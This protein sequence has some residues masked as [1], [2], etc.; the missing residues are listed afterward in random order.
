MDFIFQPK[1]NQNGTSN[2]QQ[3]KNDGQQP[4]QEEKQTTSSQPKQ[5]N[6][7]VTVDGLQALAD[8]MEQTSNGKE[9]KP[10]RGYMTEEE[11]KN[12]VANKE[13]SPKQMKLLSQTNTLRKAEKEGKI[14]RTDRRFINA[15]ARVAEQYQK[16]ISTHGN[17]AHVKRAFTM[18]VNK[19]LA[20][21]LN[22]G[23]SR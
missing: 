8:Y 7:L 19:S 15:M 13:L 22:K 3:E 10:S 16:T 23:A 9:G 11:F 6:K 18:Q 2:N 14:K 12:F 20:S 21:A 5:E 4:K 17:K 1:L